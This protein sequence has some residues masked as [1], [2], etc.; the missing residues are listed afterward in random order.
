[1]K[2]FSELGVKPIDD[3]AIFMVPRVSITDI[4]NCNIEVLD[5]IGGIKTINGDNRYIVKVR[6]DGKECK[7]FT[8]S[9]RIKSILDQIP[10]EEFP[11]TT[12]IKQQRFDSGSAKT[13]VFT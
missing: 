8:D 13:F 4:L 5:Y 10:K 11:F 3:K 1:M 7:F 9:K 12:T 2:K 6:C